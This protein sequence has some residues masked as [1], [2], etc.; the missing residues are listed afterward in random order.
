MENYNHLIK[1]NEDGSDVLRSITYQKYPL[2]TNIRIKAWEHHNSLMKELYYYN[3][4]LWWGI[5]KCN[6]DCQNANLP[7]NLKK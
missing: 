3:Q 1:Y 6:S 4:H 7:N 2:L 5:G